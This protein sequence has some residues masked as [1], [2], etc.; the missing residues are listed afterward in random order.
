MSRI[1]KI[2]I[3][4]PNGTEACVLPE[5]VQVYLRRGWTLVD[6]GDDVDEQLELGFD[7]AT[8]PDEP[9]DNEE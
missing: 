2:C 5:S 8:D 7:T 3:V 4:H 9:G 1:E 6:D